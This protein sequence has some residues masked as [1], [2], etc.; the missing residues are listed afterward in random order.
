VSGGARE[1]E[2]EV[3]WIKRSSG[4]MGYVA[5]KFCALDTHRGGTNGPST[6]GRG[7]SGVL[8]WQRLGSVT[9]TSINRADELR[10]VH[11]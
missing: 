8:T 10:T 7:P 9:L 11:P 3:L 2:R 6:S 1:R 5:S 4:P